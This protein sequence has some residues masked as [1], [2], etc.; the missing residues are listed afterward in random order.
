MAACLLPPTT[1][2]RLH[3]RKLAGNEGRDGGRHSQALKL[4]DYQ[5]AQK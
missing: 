2:I 1:W 3:I 4:L 5:D